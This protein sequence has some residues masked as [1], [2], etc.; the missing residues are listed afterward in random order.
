METMTD[1]IEALVASR[2]YTLFTHFATFWRFSS[3]S[4]SPPVSC[5]QVAALKSH[6]EDGIKEAT[7]KLWRHVDSRSFQSIFSSG[8]DASWAGPVMSKPGKRYSGKLILLFALEVPNKIEVRDTIKMY[9]FQNF[10]LV[11]AGRFKNESPKGGNCFSISSGFP[12]NQVFIGMLQL[13]F[14]LWLKS[15]CQQ[16]GDMCAG[17]D[18]ID[19]ETITQKNVEAPTLFNNNRSSRYFL[20]N[21]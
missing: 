14:I 6:S 20:F 1:G 13:L 2:Q 4:V 11:E 3:M 18:C 7:P 5:T 15:F 21:Y 17:I 12:L 10:H 19:E 9:T 8:D 16:L